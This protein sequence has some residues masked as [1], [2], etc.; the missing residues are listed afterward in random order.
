[1]STKITKQKIQKLEIGKSITGEGLEV[2]KTQKGLVF[3]ASSQT[4]G[5]R[6]RD[7][8]G[9]EQDGMNLTKARYKLKELVLS[10]PETINVNIAKPNISFRDAS[11]HYIE[12]SEQSGGKNLIQKKQHF[13]M[14]LD[15]FFGTMKIKSID[16]FSID[17]YAHER[18][19][20]GAAISTVN[21][22]L[23]TLRHMLNTLSDWGIVQTK[24]I[25]VKN[26]S[27]EAQRTKT[28]SADQ[29]KKLLKCA[30]N[31]HDPYTYLFILIGFQTAMRHGEI[32]KI[33]FEDFDYDNGTL[34]IPVA[35]A[36]SRTAPVHQSLIQTVREEQM[37][38]GVK[39]GYLFA[40]KSK[41]GH[42]T[43]MKKQFQRVLD[44][45]G[46]SDN[47]LSPHSMRH[48]AISILMR[49]QMSIAD[50]QVISGHKSTQM[51]LRY[52]HHNNMSVARGV[53]VLANVTACNANEPPADIDSGDTAA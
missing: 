53:D 28:F 15:P 18:R 50:A 17:K 4:H 35:K 19:T 45:A 9:T 36:G 13:R 23:A 11:A 27:G 30:A 1:M 24:H 31:D 16:T 12:L 40:A 41:T 6:L 38:R 43:Y 14:H 8:L 5:K 25:K 48:T 33:K 10:I 47:G 44:A 26:R 32:L 20:A 34:Y 39:A 42:R 21:R 29:I 22:E 2:R 37:R 49:S 52:T 3:Y 46:L 7:K 51:L